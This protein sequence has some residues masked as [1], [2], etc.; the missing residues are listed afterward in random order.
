MLET[1]RQYAAETL[2]QA[3][4]PDASRTRHLL[5]FVRFAQMIER[6][7]NYGQ[8]QDIWTKRLYAEADNFRSALDWSL[9][10][11]Q[12]EA[13]L[14]LAGP[15]WV[16]WYSAG[17]A[18]EGRQWL[19]RLLERST[20]VSPARAKALTSASVLAFAQ[21]DYAEARLLGEQSVEM[22]RSLDDKLGLAEGV[23]MLGHAVFDMGELALAAQLFTESL[24]LYNTLGERTPCQT[25]I[26]DLGMVA[27]HQGDYPAARRY[28]EECLR[29]AE[30]SGN[31]NETLQTLNRLGD[32]DRLDDRYDL[33]EAHYRQGLVEARALN[34]KLEVASALHKLAAVARRAGNA[35]KARLLLEESLPIQQAGGNKQGIAECLFALAGVLS[36]EGKP[37]QAV[38]LFAA[39]QAYLDGIGAPLAPADR[40]DVEADLATLRLLLDE[41][42]FQSAWAAGQSLDLPQ[43][44][45]LTAS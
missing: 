36:A 18:S 39:A 25:L 20:G 17:F 23:H 32:L 37:H 16:F 21:S 3:G 28:Y 44:F 22:W 31:R 24:S 12:I 14:Q 29:S 7:I 40:R 4:D 9:Q 33:A 34:I 10:S 41:S 8:Q 5:Y 26:S 19:K 43:A 38:Q 45:Q 15:L 11:G 1:I 30:Q 42:A 2:L 6:Q 27:Y 13:G 35:A